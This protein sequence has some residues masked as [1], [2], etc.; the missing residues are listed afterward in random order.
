MV[1]VPTTKVT[2][3]KTS[4]EASGSEAQRSAPK[5]RLAG[6]ST[7]HYCRK[8]CKY[9]YQLAWKL[10]K[11]GITTWEALQGSGEA[12]ESKRDREKRERGRLLAGMKG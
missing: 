7:E 4:T 12:G 9:H 10:V 6:C 1:R 11:R 3:M 8:L 5:C 2:I